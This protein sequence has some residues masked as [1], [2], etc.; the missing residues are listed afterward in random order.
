MKNEFQSDIVQYLVSTNYVHF[1]HVDKINLNL[2]ENADLS[3]TN[4]LLGDIVD[5]EIHCDISSNTSYC[6]FEEDVDA[7]EVIQNEYEI[8]YRVPSVDSAEE[9][10]DDASDY[11]DAFKMEVDSCNA[12]EQENDYMK[13]CLNSN[14]VIE[15]LLCNVM[16]PTRMTLIVKK[17]DGYDLDPKKDEMQSEINNKC[18][19]LPELTEIVPGER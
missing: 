5:K 13:F 12:V 9:R 7:V 3:E 15:G 19:R 1:N 16:G 8:N 4:E 14:E 2:L 6:T 11:Y 10:I 17:I 18:N